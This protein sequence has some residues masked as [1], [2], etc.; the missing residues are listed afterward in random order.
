MFIKDYLEQFKGKK[1]RLYVDMDGVIAD[2]DVGIPYGFDKKRPLITSIKLIEELAQ[3]DDIE[4]FILSVTRLD[5]GIEQKKGW[6]E[7]NAPFIKRENMIILSRESNDY[8]ISAELKS[9]Y[10]QNVERNDDEIIVIDDDPLIL[11]MVGETSKDIHRL[12]DTTLVI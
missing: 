5:E 1:I 9:E 7:K 10:L 8:K 6:L 12:K 2:Y 11:K 4:V 3:R